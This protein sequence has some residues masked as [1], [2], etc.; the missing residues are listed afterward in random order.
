MKQK[1]LPKKKGAIPLRVILDYYDAWLRSGDLKMVAAA[2]ERHPKILSGWPV[3]YPEMKLAKALAE[4]RRGKRSETFSGY[5]LNRLSPD[6]QEVWKRMQ[7]WESSESAYEKIDAILSGQ[8][9]KLRQELFIHALISTNFDLSSALRMVGVSRTQ[10]LDWQHTDTEF[11][12]LIE[13]IQWHKKNFFEKALVELVEQRHPSATIFVN[14]TI[15]ADRGYNK[16]F[17]IEH[18]GQ[19]DNGGFQLDDLDLS[20]ETRREILEAI[21][22]KKLKDTS[23]EQP[24]LE[25]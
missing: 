4:E 1:Q 11:Q 21:R 13:E 22:K 6:A 8:P 15:N 25:G 23:A 18:S 20:I 7:F 17:H 19:I 24:L 9:K 14:E 5:I 12:Q 10:L 2:L 3:K 16:K